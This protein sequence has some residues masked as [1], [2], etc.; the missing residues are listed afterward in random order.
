MEIPQATFGSK[1]KVFC[2]NSG[3]ILCERCLARIAVCPTC[4]QRFETEPPKRNEEK[5]FE[6]EKFQENKRKEEEEEAFS[7]G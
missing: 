5:E 6:I 4:Q 7:R 2:C 1:P 3:H